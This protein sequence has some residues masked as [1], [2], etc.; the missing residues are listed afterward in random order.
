M[1]QHYTQ[2]TEQGHSHEQLRIAQS[3]DSYPIGWSSNKLH[4]QCFRVFLFTH[5][6]FARRHPNDA[7]RPLA[8]KLPLSAYCQEFGG[9]WEIGKSLIR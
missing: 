3:W 5:P 7:S 8:S 2:S 9:Y 6:L 4:G 1:Q